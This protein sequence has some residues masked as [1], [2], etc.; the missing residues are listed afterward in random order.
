MIKLFELR[1]Q[2]RIQKLNIFAWVLVGVRRGLGLGF[3]A[4][5]TY[6]WIIQFFFIKAHRRSTLTQSALPL[7]LLKTRRFF[8]PRQLHFT[9]RHFQSNFRNLILLFYF[10]LVCCDIWWIWVCLDRHFIQSA[11]LVGLSAY[12]F[13]AEVISSLHLYE[14][15]ISSCANFAYSVEQVTPGIGFGFLAVFLLWVINLAQNLLR[16]WRGQFKL[17][18]LWLRWFFFFLAIL[19]P[20]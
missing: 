3:L 15:W 6:F 1:Y 9:K 10:S 17:S 8:V 4:F 5:L 18:S 11:S 20:L 14:F 16:W 19:S 2:Q 12:F 7:N 13:F